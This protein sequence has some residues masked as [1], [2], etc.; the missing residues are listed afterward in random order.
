VLEQQLREFG[1]DAIRGPV[2]WRRAV[3]QGFVDV[4]AGLDAFDRG[5]ALAGLDESGELARADVGSEGRESA[6]GDDTK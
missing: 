5:A 4:G 6:D 3:A 2:Q 1:I